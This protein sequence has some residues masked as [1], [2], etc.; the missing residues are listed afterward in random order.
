MLNVKQSVANGIQQRFELGELGEQSI[1]R[2]V[3][4]NRLRLHGKDHDVSTMV[5][6]AKR[7]LVERLYTET[8]RK[9]GLGVEPDQVLFVGGGSAALASD[10][11]NWFPNQTIADHAAFANARECSSTCNLFATARQR[12]VN[13]FVRGHCGLSGKED[14]LRIVQSTSRIFRQSNVRLA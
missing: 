3:E 8:R 9:L 10:I 4:T 5:A 1:S 7:E 13:D 6:D 12:R 14:V 2:A 11:A